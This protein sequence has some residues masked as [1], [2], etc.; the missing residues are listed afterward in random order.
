MVNNCVNPVEIC[1][2]VTVLAIL[3]LVVYNTVRAEEERARKQK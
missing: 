3:G 2:F 1:I